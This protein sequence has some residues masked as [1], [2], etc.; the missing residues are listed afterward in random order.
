MIKANMINNMA[1]YEKQKF[2][3]LNYRELENIPVS[4]SIK[5][6]DT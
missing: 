3:C 2:F 5:M 6:N 1:I 4:V